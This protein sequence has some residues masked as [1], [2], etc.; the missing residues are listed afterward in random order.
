MNI[1]LVQPAWF[2]SLATILFSQGACSDVEAPFFIDTQISGDSH[3]GV[4]PYGVTTVVTDNW[5]VAKVEL[6]Y[7]YGLDTTTQRVALH[8]GEAQDQWLG[9]FTGPGREAK[10]YYFL[11]AQDSAGNLGR[12]P[13]LAPD[14]YTFAVLPDDPWHADPD[15]GFSDLGSFDSQAL[16]A[17]T[18]A[19]SGP[20]DLAQGDGQEIDAS[21]VDGHS[22]DDSSVEA[23]ST[24]SAHGDTFS[25]EAGQTDLAP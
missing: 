20:T 23:G 25:S 5:S 2:F 16:D 11:E 24:D 17:E 13:G 7:R 9:E 14:T 15:A 1:R 19:D 18:Q 6:V 4:G 21:L 12:D 22:I 10:V 8:R 3:D